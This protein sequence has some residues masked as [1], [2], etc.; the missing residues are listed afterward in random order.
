[1]LL[2]PENFGKGIEIPDW[3]HVYGLTGSKTWKAKQNSD[4]IAVKK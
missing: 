2:M 4:D 3:D 1:M